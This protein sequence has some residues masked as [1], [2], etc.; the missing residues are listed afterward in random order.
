MHRAIPTTALAAVLALGVT[1]C[2]SDSAGSA[3]PVPAASVSASSSADSAFAQVLRDAQQATRG[4][5]S[6]RMQ[7]T[8]GI[9]LAGQAQDVTA[10]GA[11]DFKGQKGTLTIK[12]GLG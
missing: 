10:S 3:A 12:T 11:F 9:G 8:A 6:A 2:G 1:A 4:A 5:G 7:L